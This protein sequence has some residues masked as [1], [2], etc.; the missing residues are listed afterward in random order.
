MKGGL[1]VG[2]GYTSPVKLTRMVVLFFS[3]SYDN[4][5][6]MILNKGINLSKSIQRVL[7][8]FDYIY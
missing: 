1:G 4:L 8:L 7:V 6:C 5:F 2:E 3:A